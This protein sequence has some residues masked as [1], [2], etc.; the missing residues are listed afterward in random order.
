MKEENKILKIEDNEYNVPVIIYDYNDLDF[1]VSIM[2]NGLIYQ[3]YL[4][5]IMVEELMYLRF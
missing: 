3:T 2:T 1:S 5:K 4:L